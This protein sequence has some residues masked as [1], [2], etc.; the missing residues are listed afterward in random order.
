MK[1][2]PKPESVLA[3]TIREAIRFWDAMKAEG[4]SL[5]Q[6]VSSLEK[7]LRLC[8]PTRRPWTYTCETCGD[9]GLEMSSCDGGE[10]PTCGRSKPHLSHEFGRPCWCAAGARFRQPVR[11]VEDFTQ[12]GA[13]TKRQP[14]RWGR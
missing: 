5:S 6:R 14:T 11:R 4:A 10:R 1:P 8:W 7:T 9:Y 2:T 13:V 12:A 3:A